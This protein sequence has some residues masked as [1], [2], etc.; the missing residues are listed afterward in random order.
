MSLLNRDRYRKKLQGLLAT[1]DDEAFVELTWA[2]DALQ[3]GRENVAARFIQFPAEAAT[4]DIASNFAVYK[5]ELETLLG[6]LLIT[7]KHKLRDGLNRLTDCTQFAAGAKAANF[8]RKLEDAEAGVYLRHFD[9]LNEMHRIGQRQ[10]A[11]QRG[12]TN[13]AQFYRYAYIYGRGECESYF[14]RT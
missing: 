14:A 8:L 13:V 4:S 6:L 9:V 10:F 5:W 7:P 3:S 1:A 2:I 11:W 12:Y